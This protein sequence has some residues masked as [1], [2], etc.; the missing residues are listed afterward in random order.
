MKIFF[1][2][3]L[4]CFSTI[5]SSQSAKQV[6]LAAIQGQVVDSASKNPIQGAT[7]ILIYNG[8][9]VSRTSSDEKGQFRLE[10]LNAGK[11]ELK[12]EAKGYLPCKNEKLRLKAYKK[13]KLTKNLVPELPH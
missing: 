7:I 9:E 6:S 5:A 10:E 13:Q 3:S 2:F 1:I 4:V 12:F 8:E 11:Y